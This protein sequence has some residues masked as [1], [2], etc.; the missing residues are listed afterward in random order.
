MPIQ[1][2][3]RTAAR[4]PAQPAIV[5]EDGALNYAEL[6]EDS[7]RM[8]AVVDAAHRAQPAPPSPAPETR[9]I[10]IT[11]VSLGS[12]FHAARIVAGLAGYRA[13]SATIDPRG[14]SRTACASSRPPG[15]GS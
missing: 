6:V 14:R 9:G 1:D 8:F 13:V 4:H 15:S 12:A 2:R 5:G 11:A 3:P 7:R 10:P